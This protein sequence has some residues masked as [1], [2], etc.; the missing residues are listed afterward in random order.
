MLVDL[1]LL[2]KPKFFVMDGITAMEGNG[3]GSGD[4]KN[5]NVLLFSDD[6]VAMDSVFCRLIDLNP[7]FVPT[8]TFGDE[9]GLGQKDDIEIIGEPLKSFIDNTF[10]VQRIPIK[11]ESFRMSFV[12]KIKNLIIRRPYIEKDKCIKCGICVDTCPLKEK[13]V[14][15]KNDKKDIPPVYNYH[16]C[17]RCYC[18]QEMCP[19]K[20]IKVKTP[21]LGHFFIYRE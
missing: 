20:A 15:F 1:N 16:R 2:I 17:I 10:R 18:C 6:P 4:P 19:Q 21:L 12:P 7:D 11:D 13:A 9:S 8:V 5:M 14:Y 3:P